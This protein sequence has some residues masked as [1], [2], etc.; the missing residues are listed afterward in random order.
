M[1]QRLKKLVGQVQHDCRIC[2][3]LH[4]LTMSFVKSFSFVFKAVAVYE[5][6]SMADAPACIQLRKIFLL[7][8]MAINRALLEP[9]GDG[10]LPVHSVLK[11]KHYTISFILIQSFWV[12]SSPCLVGCQDAWF[13]WG[14]LSTSSV[15]ATTALWRK[16]ER[17]VSFVLEG[18]MSQV[19]V[20]SIERQ[21]KENVVSAISLK[22]S[23]TAHILDFF[24][25]IIDPV[26][27]LHLPWKCPSALLHYLLSRSPCDNTEDGR[28]HFPLRMCN[29]IFLLFS[30]S[31]CSF[32][33]R[34][35]LGLIPI[36]SSGRSLGS[37]T[38]PCVLTVGFPLCFTLLPLP[39]ASAVFAQ[40][41]VVGLEASGGVVRVQQGDAAKAFFTL[42]LAPDFS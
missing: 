41:A 17:R 29:S 10:R 25:L 28:Q 24:S 3:C 21:R 36:Q 23:Y 13:C 38:A 12:S 4:G 19:H 11:D 37:L 34:V 20:R 14:L 35:L 42:D 40:K 27:E 16:L 26:T 31:D 1:W 32:I 39:P 22:Q 2:V 7:A 5:G 15:Q 18:T 8:G 30:Y 33:F 6:Q 9:R